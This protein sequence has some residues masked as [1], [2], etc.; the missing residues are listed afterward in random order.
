M[1]QIKKKDK[2]SIL[3]FKAVLNVIKNILVK[4]GIYLPL[5]IL[6]VITLF[7]FVY[8]F[9][10]ATKNTHQI[11]FHA[12]N[13]LLG[14]DWVDNIKINY[15][16]LI[17]SAPFW[18]SIINSLYIAVM[19]TIMT[20][21]AAS[22]GGFGFS[23]YE[24]KGKD[25]LF[26]MMLITLMIPLTVSVI[27]LFAMMKTFGWFSKARALYLPALASAYG[28]FMVRKYLE[29]SMPRDLIDAARID[30]CSEFKI[31]RSVILPLITPI[32]GALGIITFLTSWGAYFLP[33]LLMRD[34]SSW[35]V[36][37]LLT[38]VQ[39]SSSAL[40]SVITTFPFCIVFLILSR[41]IISGIT[42]GSIRDF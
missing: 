23:V 32:L 37:I 22:L 31:Y 26:N 3:I 19:S 27:P 2:K 24:F 30:G 10:A 21:L 13:L 9:I 34:A 33:M 6:A 1:E 29:S 20:L 25:I 18:Q 39:P 38:R 17:Y 11:A 35:T 15:L 40:A 5:I 36:P 28:V 41:W 42:D 8:M 16:S 4:T 7:P 12:D 14:K